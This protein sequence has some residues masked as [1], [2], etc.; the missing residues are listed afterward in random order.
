MGVTDC[1]GIEGPG[2]NVRVLLQIPA[3]V[4]RVRPCRI[5]GRCGGTVAFFCRM[6]L[7]STVSSH[8]T[9]SQNSS[10]FGSGKVGSSV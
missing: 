2:T 9:S 1:H 6:L 7:F 10:S 5:C 8:S 3:F 4:P